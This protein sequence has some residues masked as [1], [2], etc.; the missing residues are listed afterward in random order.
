MPLLSSS[1]CTATEP[2]PRRLGPI[3]LSTDDD[4]KQKKREKESFRR[5]GRESWRCGGGDQRRVAGEDRQGWAREMQIR[6]GAAQGTLGLT[7]ATTVEWEMVSGLDTVKHREVQLGRL[8]Q[9]WRGVDD[10]G[11]GLGWVPAASIDGSR[12]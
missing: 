3:V 12:C 7:T 11:G 2:S 5:E 4:K 6:A 10:D 9:R 8:Q 1:Q